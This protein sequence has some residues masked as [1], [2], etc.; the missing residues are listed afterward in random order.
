[1]VAI[2]ISGHYILSVDNQTR[3]VIS[4]DSNTEHPV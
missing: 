1:M 3:D 2:N 4:H